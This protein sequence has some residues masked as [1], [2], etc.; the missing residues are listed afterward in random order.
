MAPAG[1]M[2]RRSFSSLARSAFLSM[3]AKIRSRSFPGLR[4]ETSAAR[5]FSSRRKSASR[6]PSTHTRDPLLTPSLSRRERGLR[7]PRAH[8]WACRPRTKVA[9]P[10]GKEISR[11]PS[12]A[13]TS[14][15]SLKG[16]F[17]R[18]SP[19][20]R[21]SLESRCGF[22]REARPAN[23]TSH[24]ASLPIALVL[25]LGPAGGVRT[26][27]A[28]YAAPA[29]IVRGL[30]GKLAPPDEPRRFEDHRLGGFRLRHR[31]L[32][33]AG[34]P[35]LQEP[36][37]DPVGQTPVGLE[38]GQGVDVELQA[39]AGPLPSLLH[40]VHGAGL[41]VQDRDVGVA[42]DE[43]IVAAR[44][45]RVL[46][47]ERELLLDAGR[48]QRMLPLL[49]VEAAQGLLTRREAALLVLARQEALGDPGGAEGGDELRL[50]RVAALEAGLEVL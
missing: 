4:T 16:I 30:G 48:L 2:Q 12:R 32:L 44:D 38:I 42:L 34:E 33:P 45:L 18:K 19:L 24:A 47:V 27:L 37:L 41:E 10:P 17:R 43:E 6:I 35:R 13:A 1:R 29:R 25:D 3:P 9:T 11:S 7:I 49:G 5:S 20:K 28:E 39:L 46:Q 26:D 8:A 31:R 40:V 21:S 22:P 36:Q 23:R 50:A 15:I 14:R